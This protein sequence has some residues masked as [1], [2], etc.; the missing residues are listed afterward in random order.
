M[1][2]ALMVEDAQTV[3]VGDAEL[4]DRAQE[5]DLRA[6]EQLARLYRRPAYLLALQLTGNPEDAHDVSQEAML[7]LFGN[8]GMIDRDRALRPWL[9]TVVRN[10]VRDLWRRRKVRRNEP[11]AVEVG[12]DLGHQIV[13]HAESPE[14]NLVTH[15]T[16]R[17]LWAAVSALSVKHREILVLRDYHDL[18]YQ[19]LSQVLTIPIGT[20]MSRLHAARRKLRSVYLSS[21]GVGR[22]L[23]P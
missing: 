6:C 14:D 17:R 12:P 19:E 8:L 11:L 16:R 1:N 13:D 22:K 5:G 7:R 20:V 18:S 9:F 2:A 23:L 10:L 15:E 3:P 21:E 4:L